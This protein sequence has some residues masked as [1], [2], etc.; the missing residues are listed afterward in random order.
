MFFAPQCCERYL[1]KTSNLDEA[2]AEKVVKALKSAGVVDANDIVDLDVAW[3][4]KCKT[5]LLRIVFSW[6]CWMIVLQV[7]KEFT[8]FDGVFKFHNKH[9]SVQ[10]NRCFFFQGLL[11]S[12]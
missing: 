4:L 9:E 7:M 10:S 1:C 6:G 11:V 2:A 8:N 3:F 5:Q 12:F